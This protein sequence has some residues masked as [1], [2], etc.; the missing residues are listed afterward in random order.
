MDGDYLT[1]ISGDGIIVATPTGSTAYSMSAGG[2]LVHY[3]VPAMLFTPV[4][5]FS[6]SFRPLIFPEH[7]DIEF[8]IPED[9]RNTAI[10]GIDGHTRFELCRNEKLTVTVS[11]FPAS[12]NVCE[13]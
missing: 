3:T 5:P 4:C 1:T 2:S 13:H 11:K 9:A 8:S 10:V 7:V 12:C 6:L